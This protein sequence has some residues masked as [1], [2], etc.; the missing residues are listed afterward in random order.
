MPASITLTLTSSC[1]LLDSKTK[2]TLQNT[3]SRHDQLN[4][5][6][7][8]PFLYKSSSQ[9][10]HNYNNL[11]IDYIYEHSCYKYIDFAKR[12]AYMHLI[13]RPILQLY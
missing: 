6:I 11:L 1:E 8:S 3:R 5:L 2:S 7:N 9:I 12:I 10:S 4:F 13:G